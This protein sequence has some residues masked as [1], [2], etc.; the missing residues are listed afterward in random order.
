MTPAARI[1]AVIEILTEMQAAG[2]AGTLRG[3]QAGQWLSA[4]FQ[5]RRFA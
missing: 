5:R 3:R 2:A 1:A 4:G